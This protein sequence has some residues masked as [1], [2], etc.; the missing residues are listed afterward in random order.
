MEEEDSSNRLL[1][2]S[3]NI[4]GLEEDCLKMP[5]MAVDQERGD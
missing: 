5:T 2:V 3:W 1:M 4:D